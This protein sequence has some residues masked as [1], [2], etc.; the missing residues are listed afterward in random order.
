MELARPSTPCELRTLQTR[1]ARCLPASMKRCM[2]SLAI[3][4]M[5]GSMKLP[6]GYCGQAVRAA[7]HAKDRL[8]A[9]V[10]RARDRR[11]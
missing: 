5:S 1:N 3:G 8:D 11:G 4:E 6:S 9:G 10:V 2:S 7:A